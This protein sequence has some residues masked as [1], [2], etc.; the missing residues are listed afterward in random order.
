[1]NIDKL[2]EARDAYAAWRPPDDHRL[3]TTMS[4]ACGDISLRLSLYGPPAI[5]RKAYCEALA[6][7]REVCPTFDL[8]LSEPG[9]GFSRNVIR[10]AHCPVGAAP[11]IIAAWVALLDKAITEGEAALAAQTETQKEECHEGS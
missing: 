9:G 2:K 6:V 1:M 11:A 4:D 10:Q 5:H 3:P 7:A 8:E